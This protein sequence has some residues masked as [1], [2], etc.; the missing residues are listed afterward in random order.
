MTLEPYNP[1][2]IDRITLRVLDLCCR[3][4]HIAERSR[5]EQLPDFSLHDKKALEWL[6]KLEEWVHKSEA[7]LNVA[8]FR[9]KGAR[10][11]GEIA[12]AAR[13]KE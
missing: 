10:R 11:A 7:D 8:I 1:D 3:L 13:S 9:S 2:Q 5:Q 6:G 12:G 4:R